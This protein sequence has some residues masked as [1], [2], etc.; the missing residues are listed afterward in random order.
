MRLKI[1]RR[2]DKK[3][4]EDCQYQI[5]R[6]TFFSNPLNQLCQAK[7]PG[8]NI[9]ATD[10][11]HKRG[12]GIYYLVVSTWLAVCRQCHDRI[13]RNDRDAI[14]LGLSESRLQN[15]ENEKENKEVF[16]NCPGVVVDFDEPSTD[17]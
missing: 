5:L 6:E 10:V 8:C 7:L 13:T 4:K 9:H 12:R 16:Q 11:H 2:S 14:L 15:F 3:T 17:N 1:K